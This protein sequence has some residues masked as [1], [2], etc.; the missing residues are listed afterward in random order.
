MKTIYIK[1][2]AWF[3]ICSTALVVY[4][5]AKDSLLL[6]NQSYNLLLPAIHQTG[7]N[8]DKTKQLYMEGF[9]STAITMNKN[10][11]KTNY[12]WRHGHKTTSPWMTSQDYNTFTVEKKRTVPVH[13]AMSHVCQHILNCKLTWSKE[14]DHYLLQ[15]RLTKHAFAYPILHKSDIYAHYYCKLSTKKFFGGWLQKRTSP[16]TSLQKVNK[17]PRFDNYDIHTFN[18]W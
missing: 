15:W 18:H 1:S 2:P 9:Y 17:T 16:P 11:L 6:E 4:I 8:K 10:L 14:P 7:L 13:C 5:I 3:I 12:E